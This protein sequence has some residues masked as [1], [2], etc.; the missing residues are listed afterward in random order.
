[1]CVA[2]AYTPYQKL[3]HA[4]KGKSTINFYEYWN[5]INGFSMGD[6]KSRTCMK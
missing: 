2:N 1:M 5:F 4:E 6:V 3:N